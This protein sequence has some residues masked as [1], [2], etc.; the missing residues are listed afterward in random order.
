M[1]VRFEIQFLATI[2]LRY[3]GNLIDFETEKKILRVL[4]YY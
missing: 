1:R 3:K 4:I 2:Q